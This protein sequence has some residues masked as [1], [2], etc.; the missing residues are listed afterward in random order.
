LAEPRI[1]SLGGRLLLAFVVF[2]VLANVFV[3]FYFQGRGTFVEVEKAEDAFAFLADTMRDPG[4]LAALLL[5]QAAAG[6]STVVFMVLVIDRSPLV[7]AAIH[8]QA[9]TAA[10]GW[11]LILGFILSSATALFISAVAGRHLRPEFFATATAGQALFRALVV[12]ATAFMEE[13]LFRGYLFR[14]IRERLGG[15]RTIFLTALA[16]STVHVTNPGASMLAW[17]NTL[18]MGVVLGQ[19]RALS[20]GL[21]MPFGLHLGWNLA[22]GMLFGVSV[23]GLRL[24]SAF[25]ISLDDVSPA[26][27][28]GGF[29]PEA[30]AP[31]T[32]LLAVVVVLL[33]RRLAS[34]AEEAP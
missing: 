12:A 27:G 29:G 22:L 11:G 8:V 23:S 19:L 21:A 13:L 5:L 15:G 26:L 16:F 31:L 3:F 4:V 7:P 24:P 18:L 1:R 9:G 17:V 6:V 25:R 10:V 14:I 32:V 30:S 2:L 28:G 20:G 33:G 34:P